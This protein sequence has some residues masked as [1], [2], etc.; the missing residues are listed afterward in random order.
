MTKRAFRG[1][2]ICAVA[3]GLLLRVAGLGLRPMHHD[4]A[5]QAVKFIDL[6][7]RGE[8]RYDPGNHHGPSLYYLT[9]PFAVAASGHSGAA[10]SETT[11]RLVP[12]LFGVGAIALLLLLAGG[13]SRE[14]ILFAGLLAAI[15]PVMSYYS[16]FYIQESLLVFFLAGLVGAGW[17]YVRTRSGWW[18]A[19]AG[20]AAGMMFATKETSLILFAAV[21]AALGLERALRPKETGNPGAGAPPAVPASRPRLRA[22]LHGALFLVAALV[23]AALLYTSFLRNPGGLADSVL[24]F[25][26][27]IGKAAGGGLH[28]HPWY[29]YVKL[30]AY[31]RFGHGPA[32]SEAFVLALALAG[33][34]S[35]L[36]TDSG[37]D[38]NPRFVRFI[39][40]FT[41]VSA[42]VYSAIP[43]KTPWNVLPF[44]LGVL[45]L[46]GIGAGLMW[47]AGR[48]LIVKAVVLSVLIPGMANL[49]YQDYRANFQD[50]ANPDNPYVYAQ[51]GTDFMR[52]VRTVEGVASASRQGRS[53]L[54]KVVAPPDETWPLPWYLRGFARVGYWTEGAAAGKLEDA[55]IVVT[56]AAESE[57][58]VRELGERYQMSFY[59]LRPEVVLALFVRQDLWQAF[60]DGGGASGRGRTGRER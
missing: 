39:V 20:F 55:S 52:L 26:S 4:E 56:S 53:I 25:G 57:A 32:W 10:L 43:Y 8:Y 38:G 16:R 45:I 29:Y 2:F 33:S 51:T 54:V 37:K 46:A 22:A 13:L 28:A 48:F 59:G 41:I 11:L 58:A 15:S 1:L 47:R 5:N 18:A 60:I 36:G 19:G 50:Y 24:A 7:E 9:L 49:A 27:Y 35:A 14:S 30:L 40:F 34:V 23:P 31:S 3:G 42:A 21:A 12:A 17:R 6:L 44:Y